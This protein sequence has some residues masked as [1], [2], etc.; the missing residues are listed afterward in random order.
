MDQFT[1]QTIGSLLLIGAAIIIGIG[2]F[3]SWCKRVDGQVY[4]PLR[5]GPVDTASIVEQAGIRAPLS[6]YR[7]MDRAAQAGEMKP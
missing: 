7:N 1:P 4:D 2:G 6:Q 3:V 5:D